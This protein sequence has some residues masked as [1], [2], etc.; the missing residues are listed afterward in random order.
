MS[1][2][3]SQETNLINT[4]INGKDVRGSLANGITKIADE[5]NSFEGDIDNRQNS[6]E[7]RQTNLEN[8]FTAE[9]ENAISENPSSAETVGSRTDNVNNI[10]YDT[11]G[12]RLDNQASQLAEI[13][14]YKLIAN[15]NG[16]TYLAGQSIDYSWVRKQQSS[17]LS[18]AYRKLITGLTIQICC[19]GDSLVYG[20]DT[21]SVDK[22]PA[23]T[24]PCPDG[25][26]HIQ[27]RAS[28]SYPEALQQ[29]LGNIYGSDKVTVINRGYSGDWIKRSYER[30]YTSHN[31]D[32]TILMFGTNDSRASW[33]PD[34]I[35]GNLDD[36]ISWYEQLII[37][38]IIWG[39][40]VI[41][42]T[43]PKLGNANDLDIESF[44]L[45]LNAMA[46]KY[47]V[48]VVDSAEF[49]ANYSISIYSDGTHFNGNGYSVF[50]SKIAALFIG[51]GILNPC[52]VKDGNVLLTRKNL[53]S[54]MYIGNAQATITSGAETPDEADTSGGIVARFVGEDGSL[55]YSF[56]AEQEDLMVLP[57]YYS[58]N[59]DIKITLDFGTAS[60][61]N[62]NDYLVDEL[63]NLSEVLPKEV[64]YSSLPQTPRLTDLIK[65][66]GDNLQPQLIRISE[67]GWHTVKIETT[68]ADNVILFNSLAFMS[69]R[70]YKQQK[71]I[72]KAE[73]NSTSYIF[74]THSN[75]NDTND[76]I[77]SR[78][79]YD[80][81]ANNL[82][83]PTIT[84]YWKSIPLRIIVYNYDQSILEYKFLFSSKNYNNNGW[85]FLGLSS[86]NNINETPLE[87][88]ISSINLD[89]DTKEVVINWGG[90]TT[91]ASNVIITI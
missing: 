31:S 33:V 90:A 75:Y 52:I 87:R 89:N 49:T 21:T 57:F 73:L 15:I 26:M 35:R 72:F 19:Q 65:P 24:T 36:Y 69:Y 85:N 78:I 17:L 44:R 45:A 29:Y 77:Q 4:A 1:V 46:E 12:A 81:I 79:A 28:I 55:I 27:T 54:V 76:V 13:T 41:I 59:N 60:P 91:R 64:I 51:N 6:V 63:Q 9:I 8:T 25:S 37:R 53:D 11:L 30:W 43:P 5:V 22:R 32:I 62:A 48:P 83:I 40:G 84:E 34:D 82:K 58:Q 38:E 74:Q 80:D 88:T 68:I 86:R 70:Q 2:D 3:V 23:D 50:A 47:G 18:T 20:H 56:Y 14:Q 10:T 61:R 71:D 7:T 42:L 39:K 66:T 67:K 16:T